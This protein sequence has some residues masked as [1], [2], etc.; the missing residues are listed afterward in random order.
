MKQRRPG[1]KKPIYE[2]VAGDDQHRSSGQWNH[3]T[4]EIDRESNRYREVIVN[5]QTGEV[6]RQVDEPLTSHV[7][8]G[9]AKPKTRGGGGDA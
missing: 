7:G 3:L 6:I 2:S 9:S 5:P 4:R 1:V 8:R